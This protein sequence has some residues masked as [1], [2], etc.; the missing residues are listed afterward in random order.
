M[1]SKPQD[2]PELKALSQALHQLY[3]PVLGEPVPAAF[4]RTP[5]AAVARICDR[6]SVG[7]R[8]AFAPE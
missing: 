7:D 5:A 1:D 3:D 4:A 8:S 6:G 2:D